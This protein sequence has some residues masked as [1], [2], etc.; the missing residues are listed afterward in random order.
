METEWACGVGV[1]EGVGAGTG[2]GLGVG[3]ADGVGCGEPEGWV[4]AAFPPP[5]AQLNPHRIAI[6]K[7]ETKRGQAIIFVISYQD[8]SPPTCCGTVHIYKIS[9]GFTVKMT[10]Q[11]ADSEPGK[12]LKQRLLRH[13]HIKGQSF[14]SPTFFF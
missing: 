13:Q 10:L 9:L 11:L 3:V 4:V 8:T 5:H 1:G 14:C 7:T 2:V 12:D 6:Q